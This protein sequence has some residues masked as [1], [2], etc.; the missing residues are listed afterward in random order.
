MSF[1]HWTK[2]LTL[3]YLVAVPNTELPAVGSLFGVP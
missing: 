2:P 3:V 1:A